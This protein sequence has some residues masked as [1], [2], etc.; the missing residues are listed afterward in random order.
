MFYRVPRNVSRS[1]KKIGLFPLLYTGIKWVLTPFEIME[2]HIPEKGKDY[3]I[4]FRNY[5]SKDDSFSIIKEIEQKDN[6]VRIFSHA[7]NKGLGYTLRKL[8]NS[9]HG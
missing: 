1:Y 2:E 6:K 8:F 9:A 3:E 5:A 7:P 4:F